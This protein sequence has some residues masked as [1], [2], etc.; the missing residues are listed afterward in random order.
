MH[1]GYGHN[2]QLRFFHYLKEIAIN[3]ALDALNEQTE[4]SQGSKSPAVCLSIQRNEATWEIN[5]EDN[6]P[7]LTEAMVSSLPLVSS[8]PDGTG[9]GLFIVRSAAEGHGGQLNLS[10][11]AMGGLKAS[12]SLPRI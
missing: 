1:L 4:F 7:G 10:S 12:I 5:V 2:P 3:N 9:L 8:K 11:S 6:G